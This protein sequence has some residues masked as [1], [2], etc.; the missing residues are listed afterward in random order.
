MRT[1]L[2]E[3]LAILLVAILLTVVFHHR[4]VDKPTL[5]PWECVN[6]VPC[7]QLAPEVTT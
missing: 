7:P 4:S 1:M 5:Q 3:I 6:S 2:S